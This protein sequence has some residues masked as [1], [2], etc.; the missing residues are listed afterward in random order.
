MDNLPK[1]LRLALKELQK[2]VRE[3]KVDIRK[4]DKGDMILVNDFEQQK[5]IEEK[6]LKKLQHCVINKNRTG[7]KINHL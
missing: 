6:I 2:I 7:W 4:V 3:K 1:K 5:K